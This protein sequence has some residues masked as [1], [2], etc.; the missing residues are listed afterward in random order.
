MEEGLPRS[1][2]T[3]S[4]CREILSRD[5][6]REKTPESVGRTNPQQVLALRRAGAGN[7]LIHAGLSD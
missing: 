7:I 4:F 5:V 2:I 1:L 6:F 3:D